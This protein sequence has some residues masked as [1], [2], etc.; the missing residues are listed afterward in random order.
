[1][2]PYIRAHI[3]HFD[4]GSKDFQAVCFSASACPP[5]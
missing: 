5:P 4:M 1:M 3:L 2:L